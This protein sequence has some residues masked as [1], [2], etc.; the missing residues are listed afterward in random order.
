MIDLEICQRNKFGFVNI[1]DSA[2]YYIQIT[3]VTMKIVWFHN[4][5]KA[6]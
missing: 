1:I 3:F 4:A 5:K 2:N 6:P